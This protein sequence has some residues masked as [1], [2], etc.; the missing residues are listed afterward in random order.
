MGSTK[1]FIK[2][3]SQLKVLQHFEVIQNLFHAL[4]SIPKVLEWLQADSITMS[5]YGIS[6]EWTETWTA[7][8]LSNLFQAMQFDAWAL[9]QQALI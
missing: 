9:I 4:L 6:T 3:A 2:W 1:L 5:D 7:S 8:G